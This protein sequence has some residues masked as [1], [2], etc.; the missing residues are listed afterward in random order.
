MCCFIVVIIEGPNNSNSKKKACLCSSLNIELACMAC[1]TTC[2]G[3]IKPKYP[4]SYKSPILAFVENK[5]IVHHYIR[6]PDMKRLVFPCA[7]TCSN[8][9]WL[10]FASGSRENTRSRQGWAFQRA[11]SSKRRGLPSHISYAQL[12][13]E[14][15]FLLY[16]PHLYQYREELSAQS[17]S[18]LSNTPCVTKVQFRG[19]HPNKINSYELSTVL[20][21]WLYIRRVRSNRNKFVFSVG[22]AM[23]FEDAHS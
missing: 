8:N 21:N 12:Y 1:G 15:N 13:S 19:S 11:S 5:N 6:A 3:R 2:V 20:S 23:S 18:V 14:I 22:M 4:L 9:P 7:S 16:C 10:S 17:F